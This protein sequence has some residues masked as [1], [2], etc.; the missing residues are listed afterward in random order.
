MYSISQN[1]KNVLKNKIKTV[2]T[3][4][5]IFLRKIRILEI[6]FI[7][8]SQSTIIKAFALYLII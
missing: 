6:I 4:I 8:F 3:N 2:I 5:K 7:H 1:F